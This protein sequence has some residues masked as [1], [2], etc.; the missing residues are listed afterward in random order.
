MM[1][2]AILCLIK[3]QLLKAY[4]KFEKMCCNDKYAK[5]INKPYK[6][7]RLFRFHFTIRTRLPTINTV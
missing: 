2:F 7:K 6:L 3:A 1:I 4:Q 5:Q